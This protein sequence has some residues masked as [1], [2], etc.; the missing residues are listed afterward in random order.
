MASCSIVVLVLLNAIDLVV[1]LGFLGY[2]LWLGPVSGAVV[3]IW[4]PVVA[5]GVVHLLTSILSCCVLFKPSWLEFLVCCAIVDAIIGVAS[6]TL[7]ALLM[8]HW[9]TVSEWIRQINDNLNDEGSGSGRGFVME[10]E[11]VPDYIADH[12]ATGHRAFAG[13]VFALT[14]VQFVRCGVFFAVRIRL[15]EHLR[16][17]KLTSG[18]EETG[19]CCSCGDGTRGSYDNPDNGV[20]HNPQAYAH[21]ANV[22]RHLSSYSQAAQAR[23][24][25]GKSYIVWDSNDVEV[26]VQGDGVDPSEGYRPDSSFGASSSRSDTNRSNTDWRRVTQERRSRLQEK[27]FEH[28]PPQRDEGCVIA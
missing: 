1:G 27:L 8:V 6:G 16:V 7:G 20:L 2:G 12:L 15:G 24:T 13:I 23:N 4:V 19:S 22:K 28:T 14:A 17:A 21:N 11:F 25:P 26:E 10:H 18:E 9:Q 5:L 3:A